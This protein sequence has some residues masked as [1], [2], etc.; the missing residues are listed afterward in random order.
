M[1]KRAKPSPIKPQKE[2]V[3]ETPEAVKGRVNDRV[4]PKIC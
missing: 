1:T 3:T 4:E 2:S